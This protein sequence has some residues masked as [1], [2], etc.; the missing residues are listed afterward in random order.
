M[1]QGVGAAAAVSS[2]DSPPRPGVVD[3]AGGVGE[4]RRGGER[5]KKRRKIK[6]RPLRQ[7]K[8]NHADENRDE[9]IAGAI[10][11]DITG[12]AP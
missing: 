8:T 12:E 6:R 3:G 7:R 9:D 2:A 5:G 10:E 11:S 4:G 1:R